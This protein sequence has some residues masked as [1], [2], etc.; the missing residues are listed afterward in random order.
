M[1]KTKYPSSSSAPYEST[2]VN[3]SLV[4]AREEVAGFMPGI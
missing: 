4:V 1:R 3:R 2:V